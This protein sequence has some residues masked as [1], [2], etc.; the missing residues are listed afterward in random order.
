[1]T[2]A[3]PFSTNARVPAGASQ[4]TPRDD[5]EKRTASVLLLDEGSCLADA[6]QTA[7][8]DDEQLYG[9]TQSALSTTP[10]LWKGSCLR[11][12]RPH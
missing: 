2:T 6:D 3:N 11:R 5:Q 7:A 4:T 9:G 12:S 10:L 8:S 1:V